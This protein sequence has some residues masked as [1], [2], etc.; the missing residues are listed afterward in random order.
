[1]KVHDSKR[2]R[3][4][5]DSDDETEVSK[6]TKKSRKDDK[7]ERVTKVLDQLKEKHGNTFTNFQLRI[8]SEMFIGGIYDSLEN[9]P[10]TTMFARASGGGNKCKKGSALS[11]A[12]TQ[13]FEAIS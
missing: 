12:I 6:P 11:G 4:L 9:P 2:K 1:M 10:K 5:D 13:I 7:E 8:W 3:S